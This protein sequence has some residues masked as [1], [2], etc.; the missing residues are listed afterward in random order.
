MPNVFVHDVIYATGDFCI[1]RNQ[2]INMS[3]WV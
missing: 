1:L 3:V 2:R